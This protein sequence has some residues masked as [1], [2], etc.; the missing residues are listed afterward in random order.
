MQHLLVNLCSK[1]ESTPQ[2]EALGLS[3]I[4]AALFIKAETSLQ[5]ASILLLQEQV[6]FDA[7]LAKGSV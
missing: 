7:Q 3:D 5:S 2:S 4:D 6:R 1:L